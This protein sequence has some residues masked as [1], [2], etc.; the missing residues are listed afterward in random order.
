MFA[1][2]K[3]CVHST[4]MASGVKELPRVEK[5]L[6]YPECYLLMFVF[7][8][9]NKYSLAHLF[10]LPFT[11]PKKWTFCQSDHCKLRITL[12]HPEPVWV[13]PS[14]QNR[15]WEE[16][17]IWLTNN[18]IFGGFDQCAGGKHYHQRKTRHFKNLLLRICLNLMILTSIVLDNS[19]V[20]AYNFRTI[21]GSI[22]VHLP[23]EFSYIQ[24]LNQTT[25]QD[26]FLVLIISVFI[27]SA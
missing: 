8:Q 18:D 7:A 15:E 23:K 3:L 21:S 6:V 5:S 19:T 24:G 12:G 9:I 25:K 20:R 22:L 26:I 14:V 4:D 16:V 27:F 1:H 10:G 11:T 2:A 17:R 13:L